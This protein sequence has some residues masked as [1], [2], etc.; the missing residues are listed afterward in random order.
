M[1][2][3]AGYGYDGTLDMEV[4]HSFDFLPDEL[5]LPALR[6]TATVGKF[7]AEKFEGYKKV[8]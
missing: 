3:L 1:R 6:Y 5:M 8:N 2:A 7:L 4:I